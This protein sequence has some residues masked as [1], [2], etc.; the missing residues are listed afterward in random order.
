MRMFELGGAD[1]AAALDV[2]HV[3]ADVQGVVEGDTTITVWFRGDA[4]ALPF[5][6]LSVRELPYDADAPQPTG[7]EQ[8]ASIL[9]AAD[10]L[11]RPPWVARPAGF[12]GVELVVPR[13]GA[14]GSGEHDST[15]AAL[16]CLHA[17]WDAPPSFGDVGTGSGI[18]ALYAHVRGCRR[19][20]ACDIDAASVAAARELLPEA[21]VTLGGPETMAS[22]DGLVANM[23]GTELASAMAAILRCWT[24]RHA[25]VLSGLR[26]H[27][28]DAVAA[29]PGAVE[30]VRLTVGAFTA[31]G[32]RGAPGRR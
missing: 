9:V 19:I 12:H 2:L 28:V 1:A 31:V 20:A 22:C 16:R 30:A 26:A 27:E 4:P 29:M 3:H 24:R 11:V 8:D 6:D 15:Q 14:F 13:G 5:A 32:Y 25:L 21:D 23:T 10:L 18:L 17:V 7:L